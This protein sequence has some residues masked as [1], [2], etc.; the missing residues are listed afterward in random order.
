MDTS[1]NLSAPSLI[2]TGGTSSQF[3]KAD[4]S[5]DTSTYLKNSYKDTIGLKYPVQSDS[6]NQ[7]R[8]SQSWIDS[9]YA[10][11]H[12]NDTLPDYPND[13]IAVVDGGLHLHSY[14]RTGNIVKIVVNVPAGYSFNIEKQ[15]GDKKQLAAK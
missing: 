8:L 6:V 3:L 13:S 1:G 10:L 11:I 5:V 2:K 9:V 12:R 15:Y 7:I 14:Y 4:G